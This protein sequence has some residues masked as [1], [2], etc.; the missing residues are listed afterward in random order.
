MKIVIGIDVGGST[1]KIVGFGR[2][3]D[4]L[5]RIE[6]QFVRANDP[7]TATYGAFGKFTDENNIAI[8]SIERVM[9]T[10]I[11]SSHVKHNLYGIDCER[12]P[13]FSCIGRGGLYLSGLERALVVSMGTGTALV[14]ATRGGEM[15]YL[16]GTGVGGGTLV[17]LSKLL[18]G[19][20]SIDHIVEYADGGDLANIDLRIKDLA[21]RDSMTGL[22]DDLTAA[23]F[24]NVSD[25]ASKSDMALGIMNMVYEAVGMVSVFASRHAGVNDVVLTGNLTRLGF[26]REKFREFNTMGY[27]VNCRIPECAQFATVIGAALLGIDK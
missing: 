27:G 14:S 13:E 17:G 15:K 25:V 11:G 9:M 12:V 23:N 22:A 20:E 19:A 4:S 18:I 26:C 7:I 5:V 8:S 6:P 10:G 24:G 2:D 16:G 3:G 1:T 21:S